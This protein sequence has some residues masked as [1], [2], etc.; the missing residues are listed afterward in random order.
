MFQKRLASALNDGETAM[1]LSQVKLRKLW[2]RHALR[3][4]PSTIHLT[5]SR[6]G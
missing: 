6:N 3:D 2:L 4:Y 5:R 1:L